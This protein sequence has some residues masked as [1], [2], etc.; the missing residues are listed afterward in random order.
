MF[1]NG[2]I[3]FHLFLERFP[4]QRLERLSKD[5]DSQGK[6]LKN[7][8]IERP[9][10]SRIQLKK[11]L[12]DGAI[13]VT[14]GANDNYI[15]E[16]ACYQIPKI[17]RL[18]LLF[19]SYDDWPL[20]KSGAKAAIRFL[21][22]VDLRAVWQLSNSAYS[23]GKIRFVRYEKKLLWTLGITCGIR[24]NLST[25]KQTK[26]IFRAC[27]NTV[28]GNKSCN[29]L[30]QR[31]WPFGRKSYVIFTRSYTFHRNAHVTI[32]WKSYKI[33][34]LISC[35]TLG[36][37]G[38]RLFIQEAWEAIANNDYQPIWGLRSYHPELVMVRVARAL[39]YH[40]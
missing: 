31:P 21:S 27:L 9:I 26:K 1:R 4:P 35:C 8:A 37:T 23:I 3:L 6:C 36:M 5:T 34:F 20:R 24:I 17:E 11:C 2:I 40:R 30:S 18:W 16:W 32:V 29:Y 13:R 10:G 28:V 19:N 38:S 25:S 39:F 7:V 14:A 12:I 15:E 33:I 22:S